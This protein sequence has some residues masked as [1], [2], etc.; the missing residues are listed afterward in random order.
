M[1]EA[2]VSDPGMH[3]IT[4]RKT[5]NVLPGAIKTDLDDRSVHTARR[6]TELRF[7]MS[8]GASWFESAR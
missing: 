3:H 8:E 1:A 6:G 2:L 5:T 4:V 7:V